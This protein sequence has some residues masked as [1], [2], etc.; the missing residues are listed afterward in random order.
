MADIYNFKINE[1]LNLEQPNLRESLQY[2][3]KIE[4]IQKFI[5][6]NGQI[7]EL[8]KLRVVRNI[9]CTNNSKIF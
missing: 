8:A 7:W 5:Y 4:K 2:E 9:E 1:Y 6:F 3:I